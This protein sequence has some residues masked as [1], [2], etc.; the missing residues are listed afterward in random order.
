M[1][2]EVQSRHGWAAGTPVLD[3]PSQILPV[4]VGD[5]HKCRRASD[6]LLAEHGIYIP[7]DAALYGHRLPRLQGQTRIHAR[8]LLMQA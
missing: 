2:I 3:T 4:I 1:T 8:A 5:A 7:A 6:L